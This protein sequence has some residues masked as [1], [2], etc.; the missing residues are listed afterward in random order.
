MRPELRLG[1]GLPA[2]MKPALG[3]EGPDDR[4]RNYATEQDCCSANSTQPARTAAH[5]HRLPTLP[6]PN[7]FTRPAFPASVK[8]WRQRVMILEMYRRQLSDEG[9]SKRKLQ[10]LGRRLRT[11]A[12]ELEQTSTAK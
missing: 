8:R 1:V 9:Q 6:L 5:P 2:L 11:V 10:R 12:S 3:H 7:T 4:W